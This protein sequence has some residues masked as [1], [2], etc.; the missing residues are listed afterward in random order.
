V[1]SLSQRWKPAAW[2]F[3][4]WVVAGVL[5]LWLASPYWPR[6]LEDVFIVLA[7]AREWWTSGTLRWSSG[8]V[9]VAAHPKPPESARPVCMS[10]VG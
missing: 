4:T 6:Q 2:V 1:I 10:A 9:V 7:Y 8:E 3:A 5:L